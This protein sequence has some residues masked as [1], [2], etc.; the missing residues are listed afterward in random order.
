MVHVP[1]DVCL[2][3]ML[4]VLS[5]ATASPVFG[6]AAGAI[7]FNP[8]TAAVIVTGTVEADTLQV[9]DHEGGQ[10]LVTL[11]TDGTMQA[12]LFPAASVAKLV[13]SGSDGDDRAVNG[14]TVPMDSVGG[15]GNDV[16]VGGSG[17]NL[18]IGGFG[19]DQLVG[20][21]GND[22]LNG[23]EGN[24]VLIGNAGDDVLYG[25]PGADSLNGSSGND[26]LRGGAGD[27]SL[28]GEGGTDLMLGGD[29]VD[30]VSGDDGSDILYGG[31]GHDDLRGG[32]GD[33][34]LN[35]DEGDDSLKGGEGEDALYGNDG[36]DV[37][38]GEGG[39][40]TLAGGLGADI[41][42]GDGGN[43]ELA[44]EDGDDR[45]DGGFGWDTLW[46]GAGDDV[47]VG[48]RDRDLL[49]GGDDNDFLMGNGGID[50]LMGEDGDDTLRG[51][52]ADDVLDGGLGSNTVTTG[53]VSTIDVGVVANP[54][55]DPN[56]TDEDVAQALDKAAAVA[57]QVS[58]FWSFSK[59]SDLP[60]RLRL[61]PVIHS[62]GKKSLVQIQTQFLGEPSPPLGMVKSYGDPDVRALF[63]D[64]VR[65][66]AELHPTIINLT[67]EVNFLYYFTPG[68]YE[69]FATLYQ[70]AYQL[71]KGI[72]PET[73]V[74][75]SFQDLFFIGFQQLGALDV[76]GPH[77]YVGFTT[78]P[79]WMLDHGLIDSPADISP[80]FYRWFRSLYPNE[81]II[82]TEVGWPND[83]QTSPEMQA[84]F[85]RRIPE[86]LGAVHPESI[87]WTLLN[88]FN[89]FHSGLLTP[90]ARAFLEERDVDIDLLFSRLNHVGLHSHDGTP[91]PAWFDFLQLELS[92]PSK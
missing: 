28:S 90:K 61:V 71:I 58:L 75:V 86:L 45:L 57:D 17:R 40:D 25:G 77:D 56:Q 59:Q 27:D 66:F 89:F 87:N 5:A 84:E 55:N 1:G 37:L 39:A 91:Q 32:L 78:Y 24:D 10:I 69:L 46:G 18:F 7:V 35:G 79:V 53:R 14:T 47:L 73:K 63:L 41:L 6:Q 85:V 11:V 65:Q 51:D 52:L 9:S 92:P 12:R 54:A 26:E 21:G 34:R 29:G 42:T 82:F 8:A 88:N 4:A 60:G 44:G 16:I 20:G 50:T 30:L 13:F 31:A 70:E 49:W 83:G 36:K 43:D 23:E 64:N 72:S 2:A 68:E 67:P 62:L 38:R 19:D 15:N 76:L 81:T 33:D 74:G 22:T 48:G 3:V 80:Y